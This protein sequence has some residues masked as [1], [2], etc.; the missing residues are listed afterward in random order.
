MHQIV[1]LA[2]A[3]I[4]SSAVALIPAG[5]FAQDPEP[6]AVEQ[7]A[8]PS[9]DERVKQLRHRWSLRWPPSERIRLLR[10]L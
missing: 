5:V 8:S 2:A 4:F 1:K 6:P 9:P 10:I 7:T 3:A